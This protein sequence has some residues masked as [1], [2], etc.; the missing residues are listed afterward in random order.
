MPEN[1]L[2]FEEIINTI[3]FED[4]ERSFDAPDQS[5]LMTKENQQYDIARIGRLIAK[6]HVG[7]N[8]WDET[9]RQK[10]ENSIEKFYNGNLETISVKDFCLKV[11][12]RGQLQF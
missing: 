6:G 3:S 12:I 8:L 1:R 2:T 10:F 4:I 5:G 7:Y 11:D 9:I